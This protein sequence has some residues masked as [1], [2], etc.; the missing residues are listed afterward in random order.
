MRAKGGGSKS[1]WQTL[2]A[3]GFLLVLAAGAQMQWLPGW[4]ACYYL[5]CSVLTFIAY[6]WD[7]RASIQG[8]WR[9]PELRLQLFGL[10]GGW[11]GALLAQQLLR[12]KSNKNSFLWVFCLMVLLNLLA[13]YALM[14]AETTLLRP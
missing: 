1:S 6:A 3:F 7:K 12:H 11:P 4:L 14:F 5:L 10:L 9:T 2:L 13:L 8:Q